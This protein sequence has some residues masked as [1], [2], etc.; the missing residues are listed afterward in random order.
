MTTVANAPARGTP[1]TSGPRAIRIYEYPDMVY[2]WPIWL[3]SLAGTF[4]TYL[5]G[6]NFPIGDKSLKIYTNPWLGI[7]FLAIMF[8]VLIFT[9]LR[10]R[11]I[12]A[13]IMILALAVVGLLVH[14]AVGWVFIWDLL[15]LVKVHM[16]MAFY[17]MVFAISF[18]IWF[19]V[20]FIHSRLTYGIVNPG[21]IG[22][23]SPLT[24]AFETFKPLNFQVLKRSDD[25]IVH[26]ILGLGFLALGTGDIDVKFDT[27]GGG[28]QHHT[29]R[30]VLR[31]D[32]KVTA[33]Q[34]LIA[35]EPGS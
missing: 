2:W 7:V 30:N 16:N 19:Y 29:F 25:V 32:K 8:G 9:Q 4:L 34:A 28:S 14:M 27:P 12:Y 21:E 3:T 1:T 15:T 35:A 31:P 33:M 10:A 11:G 17:V 18:V 23:R 20:T 26:K 24:G 6:E 22:W 5:F 13:I